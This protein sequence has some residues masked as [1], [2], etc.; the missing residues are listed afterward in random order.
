MPPHVVIVPGFAVDHYLRRA[1]DAARD[2]G[3]EVT[4]APAP[5]SA[6][7]GGVVGVQAS[8]AAL[9]RHL[10]G[11]TQPLVL[12]GHSFGCHVVLHAAAALG[13]RVAAVVLV[14]P[15]VAPQHRGGVRLLLAWLSDLPQERPRLAVEQVPDWVA[16]GPRRLVATYRSAL[17]D[18]PEEVVGAVSARVVVVRGERDPVCPSAWAQALAEAGGGRVVTI[19]RGPHSWPF[20]RPQR[21]ADLVA[22]VCTSGVEAAAAYP[23][24]AGAWFSPEATG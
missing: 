9:V 18:R 3:L 11:G 21:F 2:R 19:E 7:P 24:R 22:D 17:L 23:P 15:T 8:A 5:G 13:S 6:S 16:A 20:S 1:A 14:G 10:E 4:L 12:V